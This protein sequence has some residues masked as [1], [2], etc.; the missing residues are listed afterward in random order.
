[1]T[2]ALQI[3]E[4]AARLLGVL[5]KGEA[6]DADE[7]ADGLVALNDLIAS[8]S[9]DELIVYTRT[10][11]THTLSAGTGSYTIGS[12]AT[13]DTAKPLKIIS[14]FIRED[15]LDYPVDIINDE[16]YEALLD[17][18]LLSAYPNAL[19]Y[20]NG[21]PTGTIRLYP[22]PSVANTLHLLSEKEL[23]GF[24]SLSTTVDLPAG[25][26]RALRYNLAL[27]IAPEYDAQIPVTVP[28]IA[29][30]ALGAIR[31]TVARN[32]DMSYQ[33][34]LVRNENIYTG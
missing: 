14:A 21:H 4:G 19:N 3:I 17:K 24:A 29:K 22:V 33:P 9:N 27:D 34:P 5:R 23:T 11:D 10:R 26:K 1:M 18:A 2:T 8:W 16:D 28:V 13:I 7:A 32:R 30:S 12:G 20:S 31:R 6:L 15:D 25:W